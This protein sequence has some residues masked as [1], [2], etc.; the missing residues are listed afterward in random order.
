MNPFAQTDPTP[1]NSVPTMFFIQD[2]TTADASDAVP[3]VIS[4]NTSIGGFVIA[5]AFLRTTSVIELTLPGGNVTAGNTLT[6][7]GVVYTFVAGT[8][9]GNQIQVG[10]SASDTL[11]NIAAKITAD[12]SLVGATASSDGTT[13]TITGNSAVTPILVTANTTGTVH[14]IAY[15]NSNA[16]ATIQL[17]TYCREFNRYA[18]NATL[19]LEANGCV[20]FVAHVGARPFGF[21][22]TALSANTAISVSGYL[23][24]GSVGRP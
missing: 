13:C 5:T 11:N 21:I 17:V 7:N 22:V 23:A 14:A 10:T 9:T 16:T 19:D 4:P 12:S 15:T 6:V 20:E 18:Y 2:Q 24:N 1:S 3:T 8:P